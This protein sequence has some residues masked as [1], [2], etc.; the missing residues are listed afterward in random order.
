MLLLTSC[1]DPTASTDDPAGTVPAGSPSS[2]AAT[3]PPTSVPPVPPAGSPPAGGR[4][5][6]VEGVAEAGVE[7]GC[8]LIKTAAAEYLLLGDV[9]LGVPVRVTGVPATGVSTTCQQGTPLRVVSV[10]RR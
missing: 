6:T 10:Q 2:S 3:S 5:V 4:Q 9:P 7:P 8:T 1:G